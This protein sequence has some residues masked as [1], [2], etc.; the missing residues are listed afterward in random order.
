MSSHDLLICIPARLESSR[1]PRKLLQDV[2]GKPLVAWTLENA[3]KCLD[4]ADIRMITDSVE[5]AETV[6]K[7]EAVSNI[8]C[9]LDNTK[10]YRN[11]TERAAAIPNYA[12]YAYC[13]NLQCDEPEIPAEAIRAMLEK[14][15][16]ESFL[17]R[18]AVVTLVTDID[19][20][21][22]SDFSQVKAAV[23]SDGVCRDFVRQ[24]SHQG[25][26]WWR[27]NLFR[28]VG[29]YMMSSE[30][31]GVLA[32]L[33]AT[34]RENQESLEQLRWLEFGVR[35]TAVYHPGVPN[36]IN[37]ETSLRA[38]RERTESQNQGL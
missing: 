32:R 29:C 6:K 34:A 12:S 35:M 28:H 5:I 19:A 16:W 3:R 36:G 20:V 2:G 1:L 30:T 27:A 26:F 31:L 38:F 23:T 18:W 15:K 17:H 4:F 13:L 7:Y 24:W 37:D 10:E 9:V 25:S 11:G 8:R 22:F 21:G 14:C 33:P